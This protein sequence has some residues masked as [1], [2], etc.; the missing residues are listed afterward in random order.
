[1]VDRALDNKCKYIFKNQAFCAN[2]LHPKDIY[3]NFSY[4]DELKKL[5]AGGDPTSYPDSVKFLRFDNPK[6]VWSGWVNGGVLLWVHLLSLI[7]A[8]ANVSSSYHFQPCSLLILILMSKAS[9]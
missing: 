1:M 9:Y 4:R 5:H 2:S 7:G 3:H 8:S 6:K